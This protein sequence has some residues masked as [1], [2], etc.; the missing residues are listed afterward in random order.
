MLRAAS[1]DAHVVS[2]SFIAVGISTGGLGRVLFCPSFGHGFGLGF[3]FA[4][5]RDLYPALSLFLRNASRKKGWALDVVGVRRGLG[6]VVMMGKNNSNPLQSR[7]SRACYLRCL[8][9]SINPP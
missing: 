2:A 3:V 4:L 7:L 5:V 9:M 6:A 8:V 1:V